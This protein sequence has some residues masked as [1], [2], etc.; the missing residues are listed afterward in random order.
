MPAALEFQ[1]LS[2]L[3]TKLLSSLPTFL[4]C[5]AFRFLLYQCCH[6]RLWICFHASAWV[7]RRRHR[8]CSFSCTSRHTAHALTMPAFRRPVP[9]YMPG[10]PLRTTFI[11]TMELVCVAPSTCRRTQACVVV[12]CF[13]CVRDCVCPVR[14]CARIVRICGACTPYAILCECFHTLTM[15][16]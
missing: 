14:M 2:L 1:T 6:C 10:P 8:V 16:V 13:S 15:R 7:R 12:R 11:A 3:V 9:C 4:Q 5:G